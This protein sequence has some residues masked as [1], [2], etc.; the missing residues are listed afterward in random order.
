MD[1][2][3]RHTLWILTML[4]WIVGQINNCQAQDKTKYPKVGDTIE[5]HLFTDLGNYPKKSVKISDFRGR[6]LVL[7]FWGRGCGSCVASFPKMDSLKRKFEGRAEVMFVAMY[8]DLNPEKP[9]KPITKD[10]FERR[11]E[12]YDLSFINAYDSTVQKK[13]DIRGVPAIFL[14]DPD[15][16]IRAK[17]VS[18]NQNQLAAFMDGETPVYARSISATEDRQMVE[19]RKKTPKRI[20][21]DFTQLLSDSA[22]LSMSYLV[23]ARDEFFDVYRFGLYKNSKPERQGKI[24]IAT[25][26]GASLDELY[27]LAYT[28]YESWDIQDDSLYRS[29]NQAVIFDS[30]KLDSLHFKVNA[31]GSID[32]LFTYRQFLPFDLTTEEQRRAIFLKDLNQTFN[33]SSKIE[34]REVDCFRVTVKDKQKVLKLKTRGGNSSHGYAKNSIDRVYRNLSVWE[35]V[36]WA[37]IQSG[38]K[39]IGRGGKPV[40]VDDTQLPYK[41]D[42]DFNAD[43]SDWKAVL[44]FMR[45][46]GFDIISGKTLMNCIVVYD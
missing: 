19:V 36:R 40:I 2:N 42:L 44:N 45:S 15:G 4:W 9:E 34:Q 3:Y 8:E 21:P 46:K 16:V 30:K 6:W 1:T 31:D 38:L 13:Y 12:N 24:G 22:V 26:G 20:F 29:L 10:F 11:R 41:V 43:P 23:N 14:I 35:I 33:V 32:G 7:D 18:I 5:D 27:R 17:M 28:G 25:C 37:G 39:S